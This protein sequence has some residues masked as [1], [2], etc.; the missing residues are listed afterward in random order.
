MISR[1]DQTPTINGGKPVYR[2]AVDDLRQWHTIVNYGTETPVHSVDQAPSRSTGNPA[3]QPGM[4]WINGTMIGLRTFVDVLATSAPEFGVDTP[5]DG[6]CPA[7]G[8]HDAGSNC[9][10]CQNAGPVEPRPPMHSED[11]AA[12]RTEQGY[13]VGHFIGGADWLCVPGSHSNVT[14]LFT[15]PG[16]AWTY[17]GW[18]RGRLISREPDRCELVTRVGGNF[19]VT[20]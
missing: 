8:Q 16:E 3:P 17:A 1:T 5:D 15:T 14:P 11:R 20:R 13:A 18:W 12:R 4:R 9:P 2:V 10:G 7:H 6:P 19:R